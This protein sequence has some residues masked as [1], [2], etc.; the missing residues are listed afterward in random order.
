[1]NSKING[2]H[3]WA[4]HLAKQSDSSLWITTKTKDVN[5]AIQKGKTFLRSHRTQYPNEEIA[6]V[7][8][9]GTLDA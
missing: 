8:Y 3:L 5:M 6:G 7:N 2:L 9:H 1:M 4:I